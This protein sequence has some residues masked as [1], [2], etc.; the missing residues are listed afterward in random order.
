MNEVQKE[1]NNAYKMLSAAVVSGDQVDI[2]A[3]V[4]MSLRRAFDLA[5]DEGKEE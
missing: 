2:I 5:K 4:K 1:I 3:A